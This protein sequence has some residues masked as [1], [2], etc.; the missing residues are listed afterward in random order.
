MPPLRSCGRS[1]LWLDPNQYGFDKCLGNYKV[2]VLDID[3]AFVVAGDNYMFR[4]LLFCSETGKWSQRNFTAPRAFALAE[5][6]TLLHEAVGSGG[7]LYFPLTVECW[8]LTGFLALDSLASG[9]CRLINVPDGFRHGWRAELRF[10]V[11]V[12]VVRGRLRVWQLLKNNGGI[13]LKVWEL[14]DDE[15]MAVAVA[16]PAAWVLVHD[17]SVKR[18]KRKTISLVAFDP[19]DGDV[20]FMVLNNCIC[21]YNIREDKYEKVGQIPN[22]KRTR[23]QKEY[24]LWNFLDVYSVLHTSWPVLPM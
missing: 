18:D 7:V 20:V 22:F 15:A 12:G 13:D 11:G 5:S 16:G 2:V 17:V 23:A 24:V 1:G 10:R 6:E 8:K 19:N 3:N 9:E 4:A 21:K 14:R